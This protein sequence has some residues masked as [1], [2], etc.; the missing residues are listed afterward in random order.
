MH[1]LADVLEVRGDDCDVCSKSVDRGRLI[2]NNGD[3]SEAFKRF[4]EWIRRK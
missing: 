2:M 1:W 3:P 4:G